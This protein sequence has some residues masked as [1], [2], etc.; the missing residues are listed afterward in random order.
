MVRTTMSLEDGRGSEN[1]ISTA[2]SKL[3]KLQCLVDLTHRS[4]QSARSSRSAN[5]D[6]KCSQIR[7]Q[8][9][10]RLSYSRLVLAHARSIQATLNFLPVL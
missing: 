4:L 7:M 1:S 10:S 8:E 3:Q 6:L 9:V 2:R 5:V